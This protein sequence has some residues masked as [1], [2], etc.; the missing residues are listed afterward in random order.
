MTEVLVIAFVIGW[1]VFWIWMKINK[2]EEFKQASDAMHRGMH[3]ATEGVAKGIH[4]A[5][6]AVNVA[7][8]S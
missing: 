4:L 1:A 8:K 2:P 7:K 5:I 6:K 3:R